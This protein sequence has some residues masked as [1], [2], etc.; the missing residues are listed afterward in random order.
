MKL[1][2][3][4]VYIFTW[5]CSLGL[6]CRSV[7]KNLCWFWQITVEGN[8]KL[9]LNSSECCMLVQ[10]DVIKARFE[11]TH[12]RIQFHTAPVR[13]AVWNV[14]TGLSLN[15]LPVPCAVWHGVAFIFYVHSS[16][17]RTMKP[18]NGRQGLSFSP[19]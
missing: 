6:Y 19:I 8:N 10:F 17:H 14:P 2:T 7:G 16:W 1:Y 5:G 12:I 9:K 18:L 11:K 15:L 3:T 13:T 4:Q